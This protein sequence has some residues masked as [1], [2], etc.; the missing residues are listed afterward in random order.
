MSVVSDRY[1]GTIAYARVLGEL[2]RT[3]EYRGVTT[4]QHIALIMELPQRGSHMDARLGTSSGRY[5]KTSF[6]RTGPCSARWQSMCTANP[7]QVSSNS[8]EILVGHA[9]RTRKRLSGRLSAMQPMRR[10]V[11]RC[12]LPKLPNQS[13]Q[14][15]PLTRRG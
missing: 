9:E 14:P 7:V 8:P 5:P 6:G 13:L 3:A 11:D 10:G 1:R 15:T 2:V 4:Y 12:Q